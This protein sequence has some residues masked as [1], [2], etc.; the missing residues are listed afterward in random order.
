MAAPRTLFENIYRHPE[1][2]P[3]DLETI[4]E[5]HEKQ[6]FKKGDYLLKENERSE[7]YY[8]IENGLIRT[9]VYNMEHNEITTDFFSDGEIAIV[10]S[11]LFQRIPSIENLQALTDCIVWKITYENF[12]QLFHHLPGLREWG[13]SWFSHQLFALKQR[14]L[15]MITESAATRYHKLMKERPLVIRQAALKHIASYLGITDSSLSRIRKEMS[16]K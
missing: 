5:A 9:F 7:A 15:E 12:Q 2:I 6:C 16:G 11:S 10:P 3:G 13:R 8:I 4:I 14:T 1:I